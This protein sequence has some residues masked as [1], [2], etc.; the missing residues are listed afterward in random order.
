MKIEEKVL[1]GCRTRKIPNIR[2]KKK[3]IPK[4]PKRKKT[5]PCEVMER[6]QRI[7][8]IKA[9]LGSFCYPLLVAIPLSPIVDWIEKYIFRDWEFLKFLVVLI[10][11]DTLVSWVFHLTKKDFSSKGFAMIIT[12]L[13]VYSCLLI[14]AHVLG[15]YTIDGQITT[16]FTWFRSLMSTALIVRES[17]SIVENAGKISPN[18]VPSWVRKYLRDFDE[19]G[20]LKM[21][22]KNDSRPSI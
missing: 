18:L 1:W 8:Y 19:N 11:I 21:K 22:D 14:V 5:K 12:K 13:F 2:R 16:T 20:F 17:V 10:V 15:G 7:H 3:K 4:N 9:Y 6:K